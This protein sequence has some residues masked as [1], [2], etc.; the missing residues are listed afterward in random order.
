[1]RNDHE[2]HDQSPATAVLE[3]ASRSKSR[4]VR[5][6]FATLAVLG[7]GAGLTM[8]AFT[9]NVQFRGGVVA[10]DSDVFELQGQVTDTN[11]TPDGAWT[12]VNVAIGDIVL[13]SDQAQTVEKTL[14]VQDGSGSELTS[15][16]G[17]T[18][19]WTGEE[20]P[21]VDVKVGEWA[22]FASDGTTDMTRWQASLTVAAG[23]AGATGSF[24]IDVT[25]TGPG[26]SAE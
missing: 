15:V 16:T 20:P 13:A 21:G 10:A 7:L 22:P 11:R 14:W 25:G 24:T 9:G 1:M 12:P 2:T 6:G 8:A 18:V 17:T 4:K 23:A 19:Q 3:G 5:A 26:R